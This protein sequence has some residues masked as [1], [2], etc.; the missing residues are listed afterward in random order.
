[1]QKVIERLVSVILPAG[2]RQF[3]LFQV[4]LN[5]INGIAIKKFNKPAP[6]IYEA[7]IPTKHFLRSIPKPLGD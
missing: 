7:L 1:M 5:F 6:T 2:L 3:F 4:A